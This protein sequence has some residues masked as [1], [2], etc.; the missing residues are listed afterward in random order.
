MANQIAPS[1][2]PHFSGLPLEL[3]DQIW[4]E[5]LNPQPG[6]ALYF[7][8]KGCWHPRTLTES[9][10]G[11]YAED[12]ELNLFLE[13][14]YSMLNDA[15][16]D[17]PIFHVNREA[18]RVAKRWFREHGIEIRHRNDVAEPIFVRSFAPEHD[19]LY[20]APEQLHDFICEPIDRS[21]EPDFLNRTFSFMPHCERIALSNALL[22]EQPKALS[23]IFEMTYTPSVVLIIF[24]LQPDQSFVDDGMNVQRCWEFRTVREEALTW[25]RKRGAFELMEGGERKEEGSLITSETRKELASTL[26]EGQVDDFELWPAFAMRQ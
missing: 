5:S 22:Q 7:Y 26:I 3:R 20:V 15:I 17:A 2:F 9:E 18:R 19:A 13:F 10:P 6:P 25:N 21:F 11:Y 23:E 14:R 8:K 12:P 4:L 24:G 16:L 1:E